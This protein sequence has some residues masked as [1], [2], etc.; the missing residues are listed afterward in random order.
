M[1][2]FLKLVV[3]FIT[4]LTA[5]HLPLHAAHWPEWRGSGRSGVWDEDGVRRSVRV[6]G[7]GSASTKFPDYVLNWI[8]SLPTPQRF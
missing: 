5:L 2:H 3:L 7:K 8:L 1:P 4:T 6:E